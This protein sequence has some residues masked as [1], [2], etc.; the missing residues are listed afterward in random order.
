MPNSKKPRKLNRCVPG[1][2]PA[3]KPIRNMLAGM[4]ITIHFKCEVDLKTTLRKVAMPKTDMDL[5]MTEI[6]TK[7][8]ALYPEVRE[9]IC[10]HEHAPYSGTIPC[11]GP[12]CCT[13]CG[14]TF[15]DDEHLRLCREA[16]IARIDRE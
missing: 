15:N 16:A 10:T 1:A 5:E 3:R 11:T 7:K 13:M 6:R 9:R 2:A 8:R 14:M 12:K 4:P